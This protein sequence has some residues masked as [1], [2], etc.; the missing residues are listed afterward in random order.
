MLI[1]FPYIKRDSPMHRLDARVKFIVLLAFTFAIVQT[2]NLWIT[3][4]G[5]IVAAYYY[6]RAYLKWSETKRVWIFIIAL[7]IMIIIANYLIAGGAIVPGI[8][9]NHQHLLFSLPFIG[10]KARPPFIGVA[11]LAFTIENIT[12][13]LSMGM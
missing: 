8:D 9:L 6:S 10:F 4:V 1:N 12:Y 2:S 3:L 13:M 11:P 7:N 5:L